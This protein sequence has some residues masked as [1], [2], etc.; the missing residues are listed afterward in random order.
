M[1]VRLVDSSAYQINSTAR[2]QRNNKDQIANGSALRV[3][4]LQEKASTGVKIASFI[5]ALGGIAG[6]MY[7]VF[8]KGKNLEGIKEMKS[9]KDFWYNL[10]N[11]KYIH[12]DK[13]GKKTFIVEK[14]IGALTVG[15][16]GGGLI[17][18][19]L[20]DKK[21]NFGAK[22]RE[23]VIQ[24]LGNIVTPLIFVAGGLRLFERFGEK[25]VNN[26]LKISEK[27]KEYPKA[28]VSLIC[29]A[30]G[31]WAGNKVGNL[32]NH[33]IFHNDEQRK[34]K[35]ADLSPQI[36]D[37]CVAA[38]IVAS[39]GKIGDYVGRV[40]PIAM[41]VPGFSTGVAQEHHCKKIDNCA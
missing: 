34:I 17:S 10:T 39:T 14:L 16:V 18:G 21:E 23:S 40:I 9:V 24:V 26:A 38:S 33:H 5:G 13:A 20:V 8:K 6:A 3:Y 12:E 2:Y 28:G 41:L 19:G 15:S 31:L 32:V 27:F 11:V 30:A 4:D 29:L 35:F 22:V 7:F 25:K 1:S 37:G 36:D